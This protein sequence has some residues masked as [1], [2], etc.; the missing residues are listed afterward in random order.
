MEQPIE[1]K[2]LERKLKYLGGKIEDLCWANIRESPVE[3]TCQVVRYVRYIP[4]ADLYDK[5][6]FVIK[7]QVFNGRGPYIVDASAIAAET[8]DLYRK[9]CLL[10]DRSL[11]REPLNL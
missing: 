8:Y 3:D 1:L 10:I 2:F 4:C 7:D 9:M 6:G 5:D 11:G